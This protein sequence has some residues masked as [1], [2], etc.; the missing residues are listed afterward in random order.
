M[1]WV[2]VLFKQPKGVIP[3]GAPL[4]AAVRFGTRSQIARLQYPQTLTKPC[5]SC[6]NTKVANKSAKAHV[7]VP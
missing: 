1:V 4:A 7:A 2:F 3:F 6:L 5:A